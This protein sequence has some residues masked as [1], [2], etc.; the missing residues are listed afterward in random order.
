MDIQKLTDQIEQVSSLYTSKFKID[1]TMDW[2]MFKIQEEIGELTQSYL[3]YSK[4]ARQKGM[5]ED[6]V[7]KMFASELADVLC[8]TLLLA[9]H[10]NVDLDSAIRDKWLVWIK[11]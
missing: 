4:R 3:M 11:K 2:F 5:T 8:Q 1:R 10:S 6:E 7:S 9:K